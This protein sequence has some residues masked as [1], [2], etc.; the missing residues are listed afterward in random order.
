MLNPWRVRIKSHK[1]QAL[2]MNCRIVSNV[3]GE[4]SKLLNVSEGGHRKL[5]VNSGDLQQLSLKL[6]GRKKGTPKYKLEEG[7]LH[8]AKA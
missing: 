7:V 6:L 8:P 5:E 1:S 4:L 3:E 2:K